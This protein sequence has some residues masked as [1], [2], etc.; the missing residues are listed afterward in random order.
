MRSKNPPS[1]VALT[2]RSG[3]KNELFLSPLGRITLHSSSPLSQLLS[4]NIQLPVQPRENYAPARF[5]EK[6]RRA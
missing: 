2:A 3:K 1:H 6:Q 5:K 4:E